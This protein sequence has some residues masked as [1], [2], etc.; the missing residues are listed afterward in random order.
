MYW[1]LYQFKRTALHLAAMNGH[2]EVTRL[3]RDRE[4]DVNSQDK[5][6]DMT[7]EIVITVCVIK[8]IIMTVGE[9]SV[10]VKSLSHS[11]AKLSSSQFYRYS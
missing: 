7:R 4:A 3:L 1:M 9:S 11:L 2:I 8:S 10:I 6:S 5:V